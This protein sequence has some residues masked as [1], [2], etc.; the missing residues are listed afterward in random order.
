MKTIIYYFTGTGNSLAAAKKIAD[1][2]GETELVSIASLRETQGGISPECDKI[3]IVCP[4]YDC[5]VPALVAGFAERLDVSKAK[6][7]FSLMTFGGMGVSALHQLNGIFK[8]RQGRTL[9]AAFALTMPGNFSPLHEPPS[10][11]KAAD[12]ISKA[13]IRLDEIAAAIKDGKKKSPGF[14]PLSSVVRHIAYGPFIKNV[15]QSDT[16]FTVS[17]ECTSCGTCEKVCPVSNIRITNDKPQWNHSCEI[18]CACLHFC[19]VEAIQFNIMKGT[20]G[21]GR[22]RHPDVKISD[23]EIQQGKLI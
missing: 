3:G 6:Y 16:N 8:K 23:M 7:L 19:P 2:L 11:E 12:I 13:E 5:G 18:C 1:T 21:R 10:A 17:D 15:H 22:Y 9:D 14:A 20:K 4:V